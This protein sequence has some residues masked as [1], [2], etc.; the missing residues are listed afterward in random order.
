MKTTDNKS[1]PEYRE[2]IDEQVYPIVSTAT[3]KT[4]YVL[5]NFTD[6]QLWDE[7]KA[8]NYSILNNKLCKI[9]YLK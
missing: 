7:L 2:I 1:N 6:Q 8:R 5:T 3:A 4:A 9:T